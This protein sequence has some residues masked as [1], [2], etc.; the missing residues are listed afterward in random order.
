MHA[1]A[2]RVG[3]DSRVWLGLV[4][5]RVI[6]GVLVLIEMLVMTVVMLIVAVM[7]GVAG[8]MGVPRF[9]VVRVGGWVGATR[10]RAP[11]RTPALYQQDDPHGQHQHSG[12]QA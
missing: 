3:Q 5:V 12:D 11:R 8:M 4:H 9:V 2:V 10:A 6:V 1:A 7:R